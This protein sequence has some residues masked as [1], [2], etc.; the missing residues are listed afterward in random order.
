[1]RKTK[2]KGALNCAD[3]GVEMIGEAAAL[4]HD[5]QREPIFTVYNAKGTI[6]RLICKRC[7]WE[8]TNKTEGGS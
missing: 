6:W 8:L 4:L 5:L 1:M 3:C 7:F 2:T